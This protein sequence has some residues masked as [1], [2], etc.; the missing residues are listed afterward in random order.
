MGPT[1]DQRAEA[2]V[3]EIRA[4]RFR[5][6]DPAVTVP[7][8]A[9]PEELIARVLA[10]E[11]LNA[12]LALPGGTYNP[13]E[14][15]A[16]T[17]FQGG[18]RALNAWAFREARRRFDDAARRA[19]EPRLQQRIAL[20][21]ALCALLQ[22]AVRIDPERSLSTSHR[23]NLKQTLP[24]LDCL[25]AAERAHYQAEVTRLYDLRAALQEDAYLRTVWHLVRARMAM[26]VSEDDFGLTWLLAARRCARELFE[27]GEYLAGLLDRARKRILLLLGEVPPAEEEATR[28]EVGHLRPGEVF[29]AFLAALDA[30]TGRQARR[31]LQLFTIHPFV[32]APA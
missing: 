24:R 10:A 5:G 28:A 3:E 9:G 6:E 31:D 17:I 29:E 32:A 20:F 14:S 7:A 8:D 18:V 27:P 12:A 22:E 2:L 26:E 4:R 19:R 16:E 1:I 11:R 21:I 13:Q 25:S 23:E 15:L 30:G